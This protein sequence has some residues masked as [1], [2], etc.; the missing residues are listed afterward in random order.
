LGAAFFVTLY[1]Y[2]NKNIGLAILVIAAE[3]IRKEDKMIRSDEAIK[4]DLMD[5]LYW[6]YR[7]DASNVKA[8][9]SDGK[10]TLTGTVPSYSARAAAVNTAWGIN[11]VQEVTN[12]LTVHFP[13]SFAVP[14]DEEIKTRAERTLSWNPE[15]Y[16]IDIDV[17]VSNGLV[18]L[19][20]TVDAYWKRWK[21][22]D[23][24]SNLRGVIGVENHL[25][26]VPRNGYID[27]DIAKDIESALERSLYVDAENVTVKVEDGVVTLTGIVP[28]Y[29]ARG[30]AYNAAV[31]TP[32]VLEVHNSTIVS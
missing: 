17:N 13:P 6:D 25:A 30:R 18:R 26:V 28:S 11:G 16:S 24:I 27:K 23:L 2:K 4:K 31:F 32:G 20:G 29:Y 7:V 21:A 5:E 8:E 12:L 19:E 1:T 9:I 10:V 14:T 3:I 22:E 15:V